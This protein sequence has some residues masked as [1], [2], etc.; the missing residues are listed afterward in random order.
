MTAKKKEST[1]LTEEQEAVLEEV[2][3]TAFTGKCGHVNK[4]HVGLN[5]KPEDLACT[6]PA[7]HKGDHS[8]E[9]E[10]LRP[11][12]GS[13]EHAGLKRYQMGSKV[14]NGA[15]VPTEY[16]KTKDTAYWSDGA[17]VPAAEIEPDQEQLAH[18]KQ[19][20]QPGIDG[21]AYKESHESR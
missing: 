1:D 11:Y 6:L 18:L 19:S 8:A 17:G 12:D 3:A 21:K 5:G 20:R 9:F 16:V 7:G 15:V 14:I 13:F 4:H 2:K 10:C